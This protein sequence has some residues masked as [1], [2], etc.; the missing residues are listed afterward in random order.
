VECHNFYV[1][2]V[3]FQNLLV[4]EAAQAQLQVA[5]GLFKALYFTI[6]SFCTHISTHYKAFH[7]STKSKLELES[8]MSENVPVNCKFIC[9]FTVI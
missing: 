1:N 2:Y 3:I 5:Q 8:N 4:R 6:S 9:G 7:P